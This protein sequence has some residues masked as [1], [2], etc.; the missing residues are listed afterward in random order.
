MIRDPLPGSRLKRVLVQEAH[1]DDQVPNLS[2]RSLVRELGIAL[3][4]PAIE[5]VFGISS[6]RGPLASA[7][8]QWEVH[9]PTR[10]YV[11]NRPAQ[12]PP[13]ERSAHKLL[14]RLEAAII[15]VERFLRPDGM[16]EHTCGD[17][18]CSCDSGGGEPSGIVGAAEN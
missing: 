6:S 1:D 12:R 9:P 3:L 5:S 16:V 11:E 2:T 4:E 7:Y 15:Q 18:S 10:P 17:G 14:R 8:T 13:D